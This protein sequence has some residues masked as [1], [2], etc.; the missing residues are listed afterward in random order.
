MIG[1]SMLSSLGTIGIY[2]MLQSGKSEKANASSTI[3]S[4]TKLANYHAV[5]APTMPVDF[6]L[7]ADITTPAV[8]HVKKTYIPVSNYND[9][10][11]DLFGNNFSPFFFG[12]PK[13]GEPQVQMASGSGVIISNDGYIVT[14]NH[15]VNNAEKLE[16]TLFDNRSYEATVIGTD[17]STDIALIKIDEDNLPRIAFGNSDSVDIGQWVMAVGNPFDLTSTVT[18][19]II[20][21]KG[22]NIN[23]LGEQSN[24]PI[25]SF[26]QTDAAVN[27]GN[28]GGALVNAKG[29]LIGI[30]TAIASPTGAYAGYSFA[31]PVNIVKKVVD[32]LME[33]GTVQRAYLGVSI[34]NITSEMANEIDQDELNG[35]YVNAVN[36]GSGADESGIEKGDI[37]TAVDGSPVGSVPELQEHISQYRPGDKVK[38]DYFRNGSAKSAMVTL[39]NSFN[40]TEAVSETTSDILKDLGADF[41]AL[42]PKEQ[43]NYKVEGGLKVNDIYSGKIA[44]STNMRKGFIITQIDHK[45]VKTVQDLTD[46]I[47]SKQPGDGVLIEGFYPQYPNKKYYYAFGI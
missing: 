36:P 47:S 18:A 4:F 14:N 11:K 46:I 19:G 6:R 28:S 39:K 41:E 37:I 43:S 38:I 17:P 16:V 45:K 21:A 44:S 2:D 26:L 40:N 27:P 31:V 5:S 35:V 22:R 20:S 32:D 3:S 34:S 42:S 7:A 24:T 13:N 9:P 23:I 10:W 33:F 29:E 12:T 25:E 15:V 8:V 30:N 1:I